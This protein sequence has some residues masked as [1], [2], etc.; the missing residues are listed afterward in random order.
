MAYRSACRRASWP[1]KISNS[2]RPS[3]SNHS[4]RHWP[5]VPRSS[6]TLA[7][8]VPGWL[9]FVIMFR[10]PS[11]PNVAAFASLLL[12]LHL[13]DGASGMNV[14]ARLAVERT[15]AMPIERRGADAALRFGFRATRR[16]FEGAHVRL[17]PTALFPPHSVRRKCRRGDRQK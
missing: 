4:T 3:S 2:Q 11:Y 6:K 12:R 8:S 1:V 17:T 15:L 9:V 13:V 5:G 16:V 14:K 7:G 10:A